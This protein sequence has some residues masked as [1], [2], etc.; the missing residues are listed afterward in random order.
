MRTPVDYKLTPVHFRHAAPAKS[1][2]EVIG[3]DLSYAKGNHLGEYFAQR[4]FQK[5]VRLQ[6]TTGHPVDLTFS[7]PEKFEP[8]SYFGALNAQRQTASAYCLRLRE[9]GFGFAVSGR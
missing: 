7:R 1:V 9:R 5:T 2:N 3:S 4:A 8:Q 6:I